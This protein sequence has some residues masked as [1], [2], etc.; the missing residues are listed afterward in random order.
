MFESH[1]DI[2]ERL[3]TELNLS[4][5]EFDET[6]RVAVVSKDYDYDHEGLKE[7]IRDSHFRIYISQC[8]IHSLYIRLQQ[9][10]TEL[11]DAVKTLRTATPE[12]IRDSLSLNNDDNDEKIRVHNIGT[13]DDEYINTTKRIVYHQ[14]SIHDDIDDIDDIDESKLV[15]MT[16]ADTTLRILL[17]STYIDTISYICRNTDKPVHSAITSDLTHP[18]DFDLERSIDEYIP[19]PDDV[20]TTILTTIL[21]MKRRARDIDEFQ[22]SVL[23]M[24]RRTDNNIVRLM[25]WVHQ[26]EVGVETNIRRP[27]MILW[28]QATR[29]NLEKQMKRISNSFETV[30]NVERI[31]IAITVLFHTMNAVFKDE[32]TS[33][34]SYKMDLDMQIMWSP[35]KR[36]S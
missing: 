5:E 7:A 19:N 24:A 32:R 10:R 28:Y 21:R 2:A 31:I 23:N 30:F 1:K 11:N 13:D 22:K 4:P 18:L 29:L 34:P 25:R 33:V 8:I 14:I 26:T 27:M 3:R 12:S 6:L 16:M 9:C 35:M 15:A 20:H 17:I 36:P